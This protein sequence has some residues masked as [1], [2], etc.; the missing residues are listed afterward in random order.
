MGVVYRAHD[1]RL[2]R[3][4]AIKVL[5]EAVA[6][7]P[8]RLRRFE[9]E[10][11][12]VAKLNHPNILAIHDFGTDQGV[13]YAVTELLDGQD[14]KQAIPVSG[15]PWQ[16]VVE[17][18]AAIADGLAAA[19]SKGI[20]HR[21]LKPENVFVTSDGRVKPSF[22]FTMARCSPSRPPT[23]GPPWPGCAP[24]PRCSA[25]RRPSTGRSRASTWRRTLSEAE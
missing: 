25:H 6:A 22:A 8:D 7:D 1:E 17:M 23:A 10:A 24:R 3:E 21:D 20:V 18:G 13:T 9:R 2:D 12:A 11:Q 16:K 15:L 14:L 5:P 19:H 4:V